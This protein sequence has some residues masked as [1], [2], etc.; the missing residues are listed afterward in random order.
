M[1]DL[2][3][4]IDNNFD[5]LMQYIK[6]RNLKQLKEGIIQN[7][8]YFNSTNPAMYKNTME[9]CDKYKLWGS[10]NPKKHDYTLVNSRADSLVNHREDLEWLY[11]KLKDSR[12]KRIFANILYYW[13]MSNYEKIEQIT[14]KTF[15]Q[16]FDHDLIKCSKDEVFVDVGAYVGDTL[17]SYIN[18]FGKD[19]FKTI[20]CYE[21]VPK[22]IDYIKDN[23]K[24]FNLDHVVIKEKGAGSKNTT[25]Y[26]ES[27]DVSSISQL[28]NKG[29]FSVPVAKIDDD[30][31]EAVTFIKMDVEGAEE[32]VLLGCVEQIKKNHPKLAISIYHNHKDMW[33]IARMIDEIDPSYD[34]Y[35]RYYGSPYFPTEYVLYAL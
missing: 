34:F 21:F 23:I 1:S 19:C 29:K 31:P 4:L 22:N 26:F 35:I 8:E 25:M 30:I 6:D 20:Y 24:L 17:V 33:K 32:D 9:Y 10:Y 2:P 12:S 15:D 28:G 14:D 7:L 16:Y 27:D 13:L 3:T 18:N 11:T 5:S